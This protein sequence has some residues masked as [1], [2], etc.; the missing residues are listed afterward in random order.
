MYGYGMKTVSSHFAATD[1]ELW[2]IILGAMIKKTSTELFWHQ[3][4]VISLINR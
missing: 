2:Q 3:D 4:K 1:I